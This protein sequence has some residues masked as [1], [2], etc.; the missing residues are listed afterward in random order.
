MYRDNLRFG[1][2]PLVQSERSAL[3][4]IDL[5]DAYVEIYLVQEIRAEALVHN[6][7]SFT[8]FLDVA[9]LVNAQ[10]I[11]V[12]G[13]ARDAVV[14][15]PTVQGYFEVLIDTLLGS[16]LPTWRPRSKV[17]EIAHP[18]FYWYDC[19]VVRALARRTRD[20]M[21]AADRGVLF[22]TFMFNELRSKI[23]YSQ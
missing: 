9:V 21:E 3:H 7:N 23:A 11:N 5:L 2:L 18:K 14:A 8:R 1:R 16:W 19:G 4:K 22:E 6:L 15:R 12:T 13:S 10:V 17:R 20:P